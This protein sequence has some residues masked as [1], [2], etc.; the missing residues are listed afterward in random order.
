MMRFQGCKWIGAG[1]AAIALLFAEAPAARAANESNRDEVRARVESGGW[2]V[3][4]GVNVN[5]A[6][7]ARL[8]AAVAASVAAENP[9]PVM[10]YFDDYLER[11]MDKAR[12]NAP[13]VSAKALKDTLA[14]ALQDRGRTFRVGRIGVKAG[15]AT[16][17]RW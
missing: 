10:R 5:E 17:R 11:T 14:R 8:A 6:E 1:I 12:R 16:Y 4:W 15:I 9:G 7:Y 3:V 2:H 13:G